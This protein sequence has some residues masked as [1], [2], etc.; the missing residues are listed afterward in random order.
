MSMH[1]IADHLATMGRGNDTMLM[2]V[3]PREVAGLDQLARSMGG[4]ITVNPNTGLPEAGFFDF[5][6][7]YVAPVALSFINPYLGAAYSG[8]KSYADTGDLG[9]GI[10]SAATSY[11]AGKLGQSFGKMGAPDVASKFQGASQLGEAAASGAVNSGIMAQNAASMVDDA[12][13]AGKRIPGMVGTPGGMSPATAAT[14][15]ARAA[16]PS[17]FA[18]SIQNVAL[19]DAARFGGSTGAK[20]L[21]QGAKS[22]LD[23]YK[24]LSAPQKLESVVGGIGKAISSPS[25]FVKAAG[26]P[27]EAAFQIGSAASPLIMSALEPATLEQPEEDKFDPYATLNLSGDT[28]LRLYAEGGI[29]N[30]EPQDDRIPTMG[31]SPYG[32]TSLTSQQTQPNVTVVNQIPGEQGIGYAKGGNVGLFGDTPGI[33]VGGASGVAIGNTTPFSKQ[34]FEQYYNSYRRDQ[35][36]RQ[37]SPQGFPFMGSY[38]A[39]QQNLNKLAQERGVS[40]KELQKNPNAGLSEQQAR[41]NQMMSAANPPQYGTN[42]GFNFGIPAR[43]RKINEEQKEFNA[44]LADY[45]KQG[46]SYIQSQL[47]PKERKQQ[48]IYNTGMFGAAGLAGRPNTSVSSY[49]KPL[50]IWQTPSTPSAPGAPATFSRFAKG[51]YLDGP[52]DGMSDSIPATIEGKQPARLAD[53]EFVIPADVVSHLGNGSTKAGAK[54]LYQMLDRVRTART[55]TKKQG[56]QINPNKFMPV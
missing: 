26:G 17:G 33:N 46:A 52:G 3:T 20:T 45:N 37:A 15:A 47:T 25:E 32:L 10:L 6:A 11:G 39:Q 43:N 50:S 5:L 9:A 48:Q 8:I 22:S 21:E 2:H 54:K 36:L 28:G 16:D 18:G 35:A 56:K 12:L 49:S 41:F 53:G 13:M 38:G 23:I 4:S 51:G 1:Q 27:G 55:G 24:A 42:A 31:H 44:M 7:D 30:L 40:V 19:G 29:A 34:E 14:A